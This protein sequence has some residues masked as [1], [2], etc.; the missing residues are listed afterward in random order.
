MTRHTYGKEGIYQ[1]SLQVADPHGAS[2]T[3]HETVEVEPPFP[4]YD[5]II[6]VI[7]VIGVGVVVMVFRHFQQS[8]K[9][10]DHGERR[11]PEPQVQVDVKSGVEY[12]AG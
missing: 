4:W 2:D 10:P 1:I 12:S 6:L 5:I 7:V 3:A 9:V 11:F 8:P